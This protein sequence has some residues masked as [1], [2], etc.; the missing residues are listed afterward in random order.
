[1]AGT[2]APS[3]PAV[4]DPTRTT[5]HL[6]MRS[7]PEA[8]R[9][10]GVSGDTV[11]RWVA[12]GAVPSITMG[13]TPMVNLADVAAVQARQ[14]G[15]AGGRHRPWDGAARRSVHALSVA[16]VIAGVIGCLTSVGIGPVDLRSPWA[17]G[18]S[19]FSLLVGV[20]LWRLASPTR[21]RRP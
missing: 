7:V 4:D 19:L 11:R 14:V 12:D 10:C 6:V 2:H 13:A 3:G 5:S 16:N 8:A 9:E 20:G 15:A 21:R 18:L 1:M 17:F